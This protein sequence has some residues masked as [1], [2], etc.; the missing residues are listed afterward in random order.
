[1]GSEGIQVSA[2]S[3]R[4]R[5]SIV[6]TRWIGTVETCEME[7][8]CGTGAVNSATSGALF[9]ATSFDSS[10]SQKKEYSDSDFGCRDVG[11]V[12]TFIGDA[13]SLVSLASEFQKKDRSE[14]G[15]V[16]WRH[17]RCDEF[18]KRGDLK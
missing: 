12:V 6:E 16:M 3:I 10:G 9:V 7:I 14:M 15:F 2:M 11:D 1:M 5:A 8:R 13:T 18:R 4:V 17:R